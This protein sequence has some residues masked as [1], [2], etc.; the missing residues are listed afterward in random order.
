M[1]VLRRFSVMCD[2]L[3]TALVE[4]NETSEDL[5]SFVDMIGE[6][7]DIVSSGLEKGEKL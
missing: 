7:T 2:A 1:M 6:F 3:A 4:E 5:Q